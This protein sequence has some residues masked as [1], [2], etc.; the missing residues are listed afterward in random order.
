MLTTNSKIET[1]NNEWT[2][3]S[4]QYCQIQE[5]LKK[6]KEHVAYLEQQ[7]QEISI[8]LNKKS[9]EFSIKYFQSINQL[10]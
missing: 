7:E 8:T 5:K 3:L 2:N 1:M 9:Q 6:A 10:N 4:N